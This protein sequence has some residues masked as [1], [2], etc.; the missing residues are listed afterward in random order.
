MVTLRGFVLAD[1]PQLKDVPGRPNRDRRGSL[2]LFAHDGARLVTI[3]GTYFRA[4]E[5]QLTTTKTGAGGC[6]YELKRGRGSFGVYARSGWVFR[7]VTGEIKI[8]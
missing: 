6:K 3:P 4:I 5:P 7:D 8:A 1:H 2:D